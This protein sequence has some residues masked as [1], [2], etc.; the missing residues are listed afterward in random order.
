VNTDPHFQA[1]AG[2]LLRIDA[3]Q[4]GESGVD[5]SDDRV[6]GRQ[7]RV[8]SQPRSLAA[9]WQRVSAR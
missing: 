2:E 1:R 6:E 8:T 3:A 7:E 4:D 5:C 9:M